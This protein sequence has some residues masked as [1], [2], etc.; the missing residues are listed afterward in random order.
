[1]KLT[2]Q[3]L[4]VDIKTE[5]LGGGVEVGAINEQ[6][7]FFCFGFHDRSRA[8][9]FKVGRCSGRA[10][11]PANAAGPWLVGTGD[12]LPLNCGCTLVVTTN[13]K[14]QGIAWRFPLTEAHRDAKK[15]VDVNFALHFDDNI[16]T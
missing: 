11:P 10:Q 7:D 9:S 4:V 16:A 6:G 12:R 5:R 8:R 13:P 2:Q 14:I 15:N 1:M 3:A